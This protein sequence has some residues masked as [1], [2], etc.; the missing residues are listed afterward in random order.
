MKALLFRFVLLICLPLGIVA[1][2]VPF[3]DYRTVPSERETVEL[4]LRGV[5]QGPRGA[6]LHDL[7][8]AISKDDLAECP[9]LKKTI[10][11]MLDAVRP[12]SA[13]REMG[14]YG[15]F[16]SRER[17]WA[18]DMLVQIEGG[19]WRSFLKRY[20]KD[21]SGR[22]RLE[23]ERHL[24][25]VEKKLGGVETGDPSI[26][27]RA[28]IVAVVRSPLALVDASGD[29]DLRDAVARE[30]VPDLLVS[31]EAQSDRRG[32]GMHEDSGVPVGTWRRLARSFGDAESES[33]HMR[34]VLDGRVF[35][36]EI[37][38]DFEDKRIEVPV[39]RIV[40]YTVG[41]LALL[42]GLLA[43]IPLYRT[44]AQEGIAVAGPVGVAVWDTVSVIFAGLAMVMV[45]DYGLVRLFHVNTLA[46]DPEILFM[47]FFFLA[48]AVPILALLTTATS[49][50]RIFIDEKGVR[51][52]S[53]T[54]ESQVAWDSLLSVQ[55]NRISSPFRKRGFQMAKAVAKTLV[56]ESRDGKVTILEPPMRS[57]K[58]R[59]IAAMER[60][61][62]ESWRKTI[63]EQGDDWGGML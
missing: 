36:G 31:V 13:V 62:P 28:P 33:S 42:A 23:Y 4:N 6:S 25:L 46:R 14:P 27:D 52:R 45:V 12:D 22:L 54:G 9:E 3:H 51:S 7:Y 10:E 17:R 60:H 40:R 63:R 35:E 2:A 58:K 38:F 24:F 20:D 61:A 26:D 56:V 57:T 47:S 34:F 55:V 44:K 53:M 11:E 48:F 30:N 1:L 32:N 18:P 49:A 15:L 8:T 21:D 5:A 19:V 29:I 43:L 39:A 59:I 41:T 16:L 37:G 50:Q